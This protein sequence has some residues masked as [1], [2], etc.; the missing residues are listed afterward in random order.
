MAARARGV[1][2]DP[3]IRRPRCRSQT[4]DRRRRRA[5]AGRH[6]RPMQCGMRHGHASAVRRGAGAAGL[7]LT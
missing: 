3:L 1:S 2:A 4:P 6:G 5:P 7:P